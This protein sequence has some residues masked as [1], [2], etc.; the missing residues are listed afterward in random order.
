MLRFKDHTPREWKVPLNLR[1]GGRELPVGLCIITTVLLLTAGT[2]LMT[3]QVA[4][5]SGLIFTIG[6]FTLFTLSEGKARAK[7]RTAGLDEFQLVPREAV[8]LQGLQLRPAAVVVAV[9]D[10][11]ILRHL[12]IALAETDTTAT[13]VVVVT[14]RVIQGTA[15]GYRDIFQEHL[16]T[17]YEQ[18]L[19]TRVVALA[20][21]TEKPVKLL[22]VPS[23]NDFSAIVNTAM[24][25]GAARVYAG[26]SKKM[27]CEAQA[28]LLGDVWERIPI[29]NKAQF[30]LILVPRQGPPGRFEIGARAP[31]LS[32]EDVDLIHALWLKL[33]GALPRVELHHRDVVTLALQHLQRQL[34]GTAKA[35]VLA[36]I[37]RK[38]GD[39]LMKGP[40]HARQLQTKPVLDRDTLV[41][42]GSGRRSI[43]ASDLRPFPRVYS[44]KVNTRRRYQ[45]LSLLGTFLSLC[46]LPILIFGLIRNPTGA[47]GDLLMVL[48]AGQALLRMGIAVAKMRILHHRDRSHLPVMLPGRETAGESDNP[49][50]TLRVR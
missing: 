30:S 44:R 7:L 24:Q 45:A 29:S 4:T 35:G 46:I 9:R 6:L 41:L 50:R 31:L 3:K 32:P 8:D 49:A 21:R 15:A 36:A 18:L 34:E 12:E 40:S 26:T 5:V 14:A 42:P 47:E 10:P 22:A 37:R 17:D 16:F 2:N 11:K 19:F 20:E 48:L 23:N 43:T 27:T 28:R 33:S 39:E 25:L 13:D 38:W 1:L